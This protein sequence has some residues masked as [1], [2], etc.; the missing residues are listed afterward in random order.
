MFQKPHSLLL[1]EL[2]Y[3]VAQN[4]TN[5]I[6]TLVGSADVVQA[7]VIQEYFLDNEYGNGLAQFRASLH[8]SKAKWNN[9]GCKEEVDHIRRI[10]LDK[11]TN[12]TE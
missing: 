11:R 10:V 7:Q 1:D 2:S 5:R 12:D 8:N 6:E 3:H 9:L 4:S